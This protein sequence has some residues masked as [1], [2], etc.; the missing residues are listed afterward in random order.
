MDRCLCLVMPRLPH[1]RR[2]HGCTSVFKIMTVLAH[3]LTCPCK[4]N[5]RR[6]IRLFSKGSLPL[7]IGQM[8]WQ[9]WNLFI[10]LVYSCG[11]WI[12]RFPRLCSRSTQNRP[13]SQSGWNVDHARTT[14]VRV[15]SKVYV[16]VGVRVG[17]PSRLSTTN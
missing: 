15:A 9:T 14:S 2:R 8:Q 4:L 7:S 11:S 17:L 13:S 12:N 6:A 1:R 10:K 5:Y 16:R 3:S